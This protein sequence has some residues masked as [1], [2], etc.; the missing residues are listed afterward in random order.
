MSRDQRLVGGH[1]WF[2][3][4]QRLQDQSSGLVNATHH[5]DYKINCW[6]IHQKLCIG[7]QHIGSQRIF[8]PVNVANRYACN[9]ELHA[10]AG[11]NRVSLLLDKLHKRGTHRAM[12]DHTNAHLC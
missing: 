8:V 3:I 12:T 10:T 4:C 5:F 9:N 11:G 7:C 2:A 1:D 6:I